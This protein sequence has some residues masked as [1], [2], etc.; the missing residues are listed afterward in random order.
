MSD[1]ELV[2]VGVRLTIRP[3]RGGKILSLHGAGRQWLAPGDDAR[4]AESDS[5]T[6][7][8]MG[9]W[10]ECAP[11][12]DACAV[13]GLLAPDHGDVWA[14]EWAVERVDASS[15][16]LSVRSEACGFWL[17]REI[18]LGRAQGAPVQIRYTAESLGRRVPFLW[19]AHPQFLAEAGSRVI[20]PPEV[21]AV[22]DVLDPT[23]PVGPWSPAL[24]GLDSLEPGGCRKLYVEPGTPVQ[25]AAL[26]HA[27]GSELRL[28]WDERA[29]YLGLWFD[30]RAY[31]REPVIAL[32]P[33]TGYF[34][35]LDR[36]V[37]HGSALWLEPGRPVAWELALTLSAAR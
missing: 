17:R 1:I 22:V 10:D 15:A 7:A 27:D 16:L 32:E 21:G 35:A 13:G 24:A 29:P 6:A 5:F 37:G 34:D 14:R 23:H 31:S 9:G 33:S 28:D 4:S 25:T 12:I 8:E 26:R 11:T 3:E 20:L 19:A 30:N 36:A 2:G 18:V